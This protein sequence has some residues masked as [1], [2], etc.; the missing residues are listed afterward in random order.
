MGFSCKQ[1][2]SGEQRLCLT[3]VA[4][5][6]TQASIPPRFVHFLFCAL[7]SPS[8]FCAAIKILPSSYQALSLLFWRLS[9]REVG[10]WGSIL[11]VWAHWV[12]AWNR[13]ATEWRGRYLQKEIGHRSLQMYLRCLQKK[14]QG[15][16]FTRLCL[17]TNPLRP[18]N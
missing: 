2:G 17:L 13:N 6:R 5:T 1:N 8:N 18:V 3:R 7:L 15:E 10:C 14:L 11:N 12:K 4:K 16:A 9:I